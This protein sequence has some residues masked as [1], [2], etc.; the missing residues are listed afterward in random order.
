MRGLL[1]VNPR[2]TTTSPRIID[3]IVHALSDTLDLH[4][5]VTTHRGHAVTLGQSATA[6]GLD[7]VVTLGGDGVINE[8]VNG[9]LHEGPGAHVPTLATIP[10]GSGNVFARA[11]G[12]PLDPVEATGMLLDLI[13]TGSTRDV[14]LGQ[15]DDR[16]FV[17]NAGLGIDA[18]IIS[19][20][21]HQRTV[22]RRATP[23]RYLA[24]T[25]DQYLRRT[26]RRH[27]A[28]SLHRPGEDVSGV[29]L[30]FVQN[31]SPWTFFGSAPINPC[32][33]ASFDTG[34]DV[35]ATRRLGLPTALVAATRMVTGSPRPGTARGSIILWHD[36]P[37]FWLRATRPVPLQ[38]DGEA[39]GPRSSVAF[40]SRPM[41]LR[42]V[43]PNP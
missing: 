2:A 11:L 35:F 6:A 13:R 42:V 4:V 43:A 27:P 40:T 37:R 7:L 10:G 38:I 22:G 19:A 17:A 16:W 31:T 33:E 28:L 24:T 9:L 39:L 41:A 21:D 5:T 8:V 18:E 26:D 30:A 14:G 23:L 32:P 20:M 25:V 3:V 1:I 12:I 34:L 36:V 29:F 15:A